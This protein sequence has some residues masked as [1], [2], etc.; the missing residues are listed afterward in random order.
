MWSYICKRLLLMLPTG[1]GIIAVFFFV[2]E[3]VPGGP[4]D[5]VEVMIRDQAAQA[6]DG[7]AGGGPQGTGGE[8]GTGANALE[9]D[10]EIRMRIKRQLGLNHNRGE[11]FMRMLLWYSRDS[12]ISSKEVSDQSSSRITFRDEDYIV[13]RDGMEYFLYLNRLVLPDGELSTLSFDDVD[14]VYTS[15]ADPALRF[16]ARTGRQ[17]DGAMSL[18]AVPVMVRTEVFDEIEYDA[19]GNRVMVQEERQEVYLDRTFL[20]SVTDWDNWHGYFLLKFPNSITKNKPAYELIAERLP[21]SARL[22][23]VSFFLTYSMCLLF[24]IAKAVR[25]GSR[26]D[27][28]T[29]ILVLTGYGIPGFVLAVFLITMF[30]P[31][32]DA[33]ISLFPL[34][35]L[36]SPPEIY[37]QLSAWGKFWDNVHHMIAPIICLTI[38]SFAG[39]TLLTKNSVLEE[40]DQLYATAA[41]ARGLSE[42]KVLFK[43][44]LRNSLIPL[45]TG[46]PARFVMMF[47]AGS[48]LIEKIFSL[49]GLGLLSYNALVERDYP[50]TI[51]SMFVFTYIG[52]FC[53]LLSD[54]GYVIVDP[55]I[56]F[57]EKS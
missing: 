51:S 53:Q 11:R 12:L 29:S 38:G 27:T 54:I 6:Q 8:G 22:G 39:L 55:R 48:V 13:F 4:L 50:L 5:Q 35:G 15:S 40:F 17:L 1:I 28:V 2:S 7:G 24:G 33:I 42:R 32:G 25:N 44:I 30:G 36:H 10:P 20:A 19:S 49:D 47:F 52:L 43:H 23:V 26:F 41:R 57:E 56:S 21:V 37:A 34:R 46:F 31:G 18:T 45:I 3:I 9:I 16:D 14:Q